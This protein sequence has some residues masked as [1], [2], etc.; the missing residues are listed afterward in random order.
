MQKMCVS[1]F[2]WF[3]ISLRASMLVRPR[4]R[5]PRVEPWWHNFNGIQVKHLKPS[6]PTPHSTEYGGKLFQ[7]LWI[8]S[9]YF[10][11]GIAHLNV[12]SLIQKKKS[13]LSRP[14]AD[15]LVLSEAWLI[16][17]I[18]DNDIAL[19]GI[20]CFRDDRK[21]CCSLFENILSRL[22]L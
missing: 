11:S 19:E 4:H 9:N 13:G 8:C 3:V 12:Y 18:S 21:S 1:L 20:H 15:I 6:P 5:H 17:S 10:G 22:C 7:F 14:K 2:Y 16:N